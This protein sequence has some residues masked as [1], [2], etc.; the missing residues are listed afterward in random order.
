MSPAAKSKRTSQAQ[1]LAASQA[2]SQAQ[3][4][5]HVAS[6]LSSADATAAQRVQT[7]GLVHQARQNQLTR[8]AKLVVAKYGATSTQATTA[9]ADV[10][11]SRIAVARIA[12]AGRQVASAAP[13]VA[14]KGWALYGHVYDSQLQPAPAHTVFLVDEQKAYRHEY[15]FAY[16]TA[17]GSFSIEYP[18]CDEE[19][20]K[21]S[22]YLEIVNAH[23]QPV[24]LSTAA[25]EPKTGTATYQD[26]T[27]PAGEAPIGDPPPEIRVIAQPKWPKP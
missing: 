14:A 6:A 18:G 21:R 15:G 1:S 10:S 7:L 9:N 20:A 22:L 26:V 27:L 13:K 23:A 24:Y 17:D 3:I 19:R 11:A 25:F 2:T 16:T 12:Q 8:T 5:T 4:Q